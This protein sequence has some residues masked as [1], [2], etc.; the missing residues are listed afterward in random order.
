MNW[1]IVAATAEFNRVKLHGFG[2][3]SDSA[4]WW[5]SVLDQQ[6]DTPDTFTAN[7]LYQDHSGEA[8]LNPLPYDTFPAKVR[9]GARAAGVS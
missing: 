3:S 6:M 7:G 2:A 9:R 1:G 5:E 4:G 8:G